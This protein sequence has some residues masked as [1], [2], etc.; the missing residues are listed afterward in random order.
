MIPSCEAIL[1]SCRRPQKKT[2]RPKPAGC[3][4]TAS[5][6]TTLHLRPMFILWA[7]LSDWADRTFR[8]F[9][10]HASPLYCWR[11]E[12]PLQQAL[13]GQDWGD[14]PHNW[15]SAECVRYL[16]HMLLLEDGTSL[17]L[18]AGA[19]SNLEQKVFSLENSPTRFGRVSLRLE[20][21]WGPR[22]SGW[23]LDF[24]LAGAETAGARPDSGDHHRPA[25]R[26]RGECNR[27]CQPKDR[28][29]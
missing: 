18:L 25:I 1:R 19:T 22:Q 27:C 4:T 16:R 10:N 7:G 8:G 5:G 26:S 29:S 24:A 17:R 21:S 28:G 12:Q 23:K 13:V 14:M 20:L 9:L 11:E 3:G 6:T 2:F 15:A